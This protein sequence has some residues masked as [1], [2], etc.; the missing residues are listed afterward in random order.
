MNM[1]KNKSIEHVWSI[2]CSSS[3]LDSETNNLTLSNLI[4]KITIDIPEDELKKIKE[5][6][7][8]GILFPMNFEVV[9]RF[10]KIDKDK[11]VPPFSY[12]IVMQNPEGKTM[13]SSNEQQINFPKGIYNMRVRTRLNQ[14]PIQ[15]TGDYFISIQTK[16]SGSD[17]FEEVYLIPLEMITNYA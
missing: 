13:L 11:D 12:Q 4:E 16:D 1:K 17:K 7:S 9:S 6:K 3:I 8:E 5:A 14:L 15:K 2:I 10:R